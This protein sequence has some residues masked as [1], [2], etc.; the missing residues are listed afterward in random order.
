MYQVQLE[1]GVKSLIQTV[2]SSSFSVAPSGGIF[3]LKPSGV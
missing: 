3:L 1:S 2:G